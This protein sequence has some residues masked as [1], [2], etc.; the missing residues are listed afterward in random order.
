M[1]AN[2]LGNYTYHSVPSTS[3]TTPFNGGA[4]DSLLLFGSSGVNCFGALLCVD[5]A[6]DGNRIAAVYKVKM[7]RDALFG[8]GTIMGV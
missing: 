2:C 4:F 6:L 3:K 7:G 8:K 1:T 5:M